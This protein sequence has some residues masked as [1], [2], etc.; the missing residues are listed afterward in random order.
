[1]T[2]T[3]RIVTACGAVF[4]VAAS[5][6]A[7]NLDTERA[8]NAELMADAE[9]R[10]SLLAFPFFAPPAGGGFRI[11]AGD[12]SLHFEGHSAFRYTANIGSET[13]DRDNATGF[14]FTQ[15]QL[16]FSGD[17]NEDFSWRIQFD[18][19]DDSTGFAVLEDAILTYETENGITLGAG[20]AFLPITHAHY[21]VDQNK[22][23]GAST[24]VGAEQLGGGR[25]QGVFASGHAGE[26]FEWILAISDGVRAANTSFTSSAEADFAITARGNYIF[27]GEAADFSHASSFRGAET[28]SYVGGVFHYQTG[29]ETIGT[30][31]TDIT[32]FGF[33]GQYKSDGW[34]AGGWFT[35]INTEPEF[36]DDTTALSVGASG[37]Y[38]FDDNWEGFAGWECLNL[39]DDSLREDTF[40]F[41]NFGANYFFIPESYAIRGIIDVLIALEEVDGL[42]SSTTQATGILNTEESGTV[43]LRLG[44]DFSF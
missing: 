32:I 27:E 36:G 37:S 44:V 34:Q 18:L 9:A 43:A 10:S 2:Q 23:L 15:T 3:T 30:S 7:Q 40:N 22:Q 35:Y 6:S 1:M 17:I 31:D 11:D 41:L 4:A 26:N 13:T 5:A 25:S 12:A 21:R 16:E 29:G 8:Y 38:F 14:N 28:S 39:D 42:S 19:N 24:S 33:D 20:Q